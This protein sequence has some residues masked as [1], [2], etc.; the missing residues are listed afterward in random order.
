M[1]A[2]NSIVVR[3]LEILRALI[4]QNEEE[5]GT[6]VEAYKNIDVDALPDVLDRTSWGRDQ[7]QM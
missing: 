2:D 4:A 6:P 1:S 3:L 5:E 7:Q